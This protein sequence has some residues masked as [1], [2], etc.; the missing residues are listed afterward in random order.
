MPRQ[1]PIAATDA[2]AL[3]NPRPAPSRVDETRSPRHRGLRLHRRAAAPAILMAMAAATIAWTP[4]GAQA[5]QVAG[6]AIG[7]VNR[8]QTPRSTAESANQGT[9]GTVGAPAATETSAS[10]RGTASIA[11]HPATVTLPATPSDRS[12]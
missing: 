11:T 8:A 2:G 4:I 3:S 5:S 6:G 10:T 12:R 1:T 9:T 7:S